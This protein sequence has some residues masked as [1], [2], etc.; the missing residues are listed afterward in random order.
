MEDLLHYGIGI[1]ELLPFPEYAV[2]G[3]AWIVAPEHDFVLEPGAHVDLE[4]RRKVLRRPARHLPVDVAFMQRH[5][6]RLIHPRPPR[7]G[8]DDREI[9]E[10]GCEIVYRSGMCVPDSRAH[11][12]W[13]A[14]AH[15]GRPHIDHHRS[16]Q[17]V[18]YFEQRI[19]TPVVHRKVLHDGMEVKSNQ[20]Q[21]SDSSSRLPYRLLASRRLQ[22][23]PCLDD[24]R[25]IALPHCM[26]VVVAARWRGDGGLQIERYQDGVHARGGEIPD[27]LHL[28]LRGP[29]AIPVLAERFYVWP[30]AVY[31]F[32]RAGV[33]VQV[34]DPHSLYRSFRSLFTV[35]RSRA[36]C[37]STL[38]PYRQPPTDSRAVG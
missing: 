33:T 23:A 8:H 11:A 2:I 9:R 29:R 13:P 17:L 35:H 21:L 32:L 36:S 22:R 1:A 14:S 6:R 38:T 34:D 7:M 5:G 28:G 30:L 24:S 15:S 3:Q 26:H 31:P 19:V 16:F 4:L 25:R 18:D 27:D 12:A 37:E 10:V 20:A